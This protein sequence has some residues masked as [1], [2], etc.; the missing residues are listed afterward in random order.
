MKKRLITELA[1]YSIDEEKETLPVSVFN[2]LY[3]KKTAEIVYVTKGGK[4]YGIVAMME[5]LNPIVCGEVQ[6]NKHYTSL[7]GFNIIKA[8]EIF[9]RWFNIHK[10]PVIDSEGKLLGDYSAWDDELYIERN[11]I[12]QG[13][14]EMVKKILNEYKMTYIVEPVIE[15]YYLYLRLKE[16][17][18]SHQIHYT[19]L[20]KEEVRR[21]LAEKSIC[22]FLDEDEKRGI[23]CLYSLEP[24]INN[25]R[26]CNM[27]KYDMLADARW[28]IR[29][30]TYKS[31]LLQV[32]Q[33]LC[34]RR[35]NIREAGYM[36]YGRLADKALV[37]LSA[38]KQKGVSCFCLYGESGE[39]TE[40]ETS[41]RKKV[42]ER[43]NSIKQKGRMWEESAE[44]EAFYAELYQ[45]EDYRNMSAHEEI[46]NGVHSFEYKKNIEGKYFNAREGRRVTCFQPEKYAGT[47]Y[48]FGPCTVI[49]LYAED[50]YTIAS[51]LQKKLMDMGYAYR[52]EN[53]GAMMRND[54]EIDTKLEEVGR[55]YE[56]DIVILLLEKGK[57]PGIQS[58]F[59]EKI[60]EQNKVPAEWVIDSYEHCNHKVNELIADHLMKMIHPCLRLGEI[61]SREVHIDVHDVMR[62]YICEK[63]LEQYF[64]D[65]D[66]YKYN[67]VGAV[68]M[69][70]NPFSNGHRYLIEQAMQQVEYLIVFVVEEDASLFP[71][72]ERF[73]LV[74]EGTKDL[75]NVKV[76]PSGDFIL[77]KNN[78]K[79]Y[80]SKQDAAAAMNAEYDIT[81]FAD[82]IAKP[83]NITHRFAGEEPKDRTTRI[84]NEAMRNVLLRQEIN[85][86]EIPRIMS[87][88]EVVSASLIR[89]Y[90][91]EERYEDVSFLIPEST[92]KYFR[93]QI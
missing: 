77:S 53:Y 16:Y 61:V 66:G 91:R 11:Y 60:Y 80:F 48:L 82:Y 54:S 56:N 75:V 29:F 15:K 20:K 81:L 76:V 93:E 14:E 31:L 73:K 30:A 69:N 42:A 62:R 4:L 5:M 32:E 33:E 8:H 39:D 72:E 47:V 36:E 1:V 64:K 24:D 12:M 3:L 44:Q 9:N 92:W 45:N 88:K 23:Q 7:T 50:Q 86:V 37:L 87:G 55:Y 13:Q 17:L 40:Y 57:V 83:L 74:K 89:K 43:V 27:F 65:F 35:L 21:V 67:T 90:L 58:A 2:D 26:G 59:L 28:K 52:V 68:V 85:Y 41:F 38:L 25:V 78:F 22:I 18:D 34:F 19:I 84:Y 63:Y 71:F 10:I 70:C 51:C 49:G 79:E 6:I 46:F